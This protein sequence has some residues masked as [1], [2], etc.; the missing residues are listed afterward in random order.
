MRDERDEEDRGPC[1]A[2]ESHRLD[3]DTSARRRTSCDDFCVEHA[4]VGGVE[5]LRPYGSVM[6]RRLWRSVSASRSASCD[7]A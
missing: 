4:A 1:A 5:E 6:R 7:R 3:Y 2:A